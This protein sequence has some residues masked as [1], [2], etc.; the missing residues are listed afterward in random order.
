MWTVFWSWLF[1]GD[2]VTP[3]VWLALILIVGAVG[4]SQA[5]WE[6][7]LSRRWRPPE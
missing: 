5:N 1:F 2:P 6:K 7:L 3:N 4:I